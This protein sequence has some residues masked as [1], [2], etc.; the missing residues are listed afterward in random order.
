MKL[1]LVRHCQSEWQ[2]GASRDLDAALT[3]L[4]RSQ[5]DHVAGWAQQRLTPGTELLVSPLVRAM[6]TAEAMAKRARLTVSTR[7]SLVEAPFHVGSLLPASPAPFAKP[8]DTPLPVPL[9]GFVERVR[10]FVRDVITDGCGQAVCVT[11][12]GVIEAMLR[13]VL[14]CVN[15]RFDIDNGSVTVI[16]WTGSCWRLSQ[17]NGLDHMPCGLRSS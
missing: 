3:P 12:S 5:A 6:A 16:E 13:I 9:R 11:H 15:V 17:L 2:T 10:V 8:A 7:E 1:V 14:D 4:G